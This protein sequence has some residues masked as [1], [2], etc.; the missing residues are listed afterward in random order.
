MEIGVLYDGSLG[1]FSEVIPR[2]GG[3][4]PV[5][6]TTHHLHTIILHS[7]AVSKDSAYGAKGLGIY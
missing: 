3:L 6:S 4:S 7:H 1:G 5:S 2:R